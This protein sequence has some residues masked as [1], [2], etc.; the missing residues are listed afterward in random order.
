MVGRV[1]YDQL[2]KYILRRGYARVVYHGV[3]CGSVSYK[4]KL[5]DLLLL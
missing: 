5:W 2:V 4:N 3:W 1:E